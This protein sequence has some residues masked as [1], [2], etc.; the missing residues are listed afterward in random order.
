MKRKGGVISRPFSPVFKNSLTY[1]LR[2]VLRQASFDLFDHVA[3]YITP[4]PLSTDSMMA[5]AITEPI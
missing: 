4:I 1:I 2:D 5:A 3:L